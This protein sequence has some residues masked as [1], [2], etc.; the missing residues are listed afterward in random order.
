M[1]P[2]SHIIII[3]NSNANL[4]NLITKY[5]QLNIHDVTS[6]VNTFLINITIKEHNS[7]QMCHCVANSITKSEH[8]NIVTE[9]IKYKM[10]HMSVG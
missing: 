10:V 3:P 4:H 8:L 2:V 1:S 9:V 6:H 5:G 7:V